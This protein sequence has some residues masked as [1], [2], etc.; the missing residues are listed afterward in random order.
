MW[1]LP[2]TGWWLNR[3]QEW[4]DMKIKA[5]ATCSACMVLLLTASF[6]I[7]QGKA[8]ENPIKAKNLILMENGE[9]SVEGLPGRRD[10]SRYGQGGHYDFRTNPLGVRKGNQT[11]SDLAEF[12]T[13]NLIEKHLGYVRV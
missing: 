1:N 4:N 7:A 9:T 12:L 3:N 5:F 13:T 2:G 8:I 6:A 11:L 10:L